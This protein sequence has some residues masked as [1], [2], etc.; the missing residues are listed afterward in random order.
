MY[1]EYIYY[2]SGNLAFE[3]RTPSYSGW[4]HHLVRGHYPNFFETQGAREVMEECLHGYCCDPPIL[5]GRAKLS[6][7]GLLP[8]EHSHIVHGLGKATDVRGGFWTSSIHILVFPSPKRKKKK[9]WCSCHRRECEV[10]RPIL[11]MA[12]HDTIYDLVS[13]SQKVGSIVCLGSRHSP[14][15]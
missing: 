2:G 1:A 3:F 5:V 10:A 11:I 6:V 9:S 13:S 7:G 12:D 14:S 4:A 15:S 8:I